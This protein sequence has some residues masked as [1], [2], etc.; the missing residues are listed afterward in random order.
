[1]LSTFK[2][3][4]VKQSI[5]RS[6][7]CIL[8]QI[9]MSVL[10]PATVWAQVS[11]TAASASGNFA[12]QAIGL[13]SA[14][15]T[16]S[17]SVSSG[18]TVG[19]VAVVTT[20]IVNLD[21]ANAAGSSCTAKLYSSA[22]ACAVN[23]TFTPTAAGLRMGAV[24]FYSKAKNA[25]TVLKSVP[26]YGIGIGPQ[27]AYGPGTLLV[28]DAAAFNGK[29][30]RTGL[31]N[32]RAVAADA[33]GNL[34]ILDDDNDP[35]GYRLV[36]VPAG[37]GTPT[38]SDP[39]VNGEALYLPSCL[40]VDG[41]GDLF[42]GDFYGRVVEVPTGGGTATAIYPAANGIA[43][44]Y[45]SGLAVDG[46]GDLFIA[47]FMN[48][49]VLEMPAAGGAA[50][51]ID[52][53]VNGVPLENP[54]GV[55]VDGAGD[56]FIADLANSR[57]IEVPAGGGAATAINPAVNGVRL[58]SPTGI[59]ADGAG[60]LFISDG[61]NH[62]VAVVAAGGGAA[63]SI[64]E[65]LYDEGLGEVY[66]VTVDG[67]G[68][69]FIVEGGLEGGHNIVE[70]L[71]RSKPPALA[72]PTLT[73]VG[74]TDITDGVQTVEIM[75]IGNEPLTLTA[76]GY[77][78]DFPE[79]GGDANACT[80]STNLSAGQDCDVSVEFSASNS[81]ALSEGVALSD[82]A[83]NASGAQQSIPAAATGEALAALIS[84]TPGNVLPGP[85]VTFTWTGSA[86]A[87]YYWLSVG[88]TGVGSNNL[89]M[90]GK[91]PIT[92]CT[93]GGLPTNGQTV[94]VRLTT[95]FGTVQLYTDYTYTAVTLAALTSPVPGAVLTGP[96]VTFSW[97]AGTSATGYS[98]WFGSTGV[99]SYNLKYT[100]ETTA[101]SSTVTG[102]PT[103]GQTIYVRLYT[104]FN[105]VTAHT[106]YTYTAAP[107]G[108]P[109]TMISPTSGST[110]GTSNVVF[111][112]TAGT[113][114][115][116]YNLWLGLSGPGSSSLYTSGWLTTTSTMVTKLP[117]KG[118]K[119]YAR[120]YSLVYG[121][122]QY[123]DYTYTEQ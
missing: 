27:I 85:T 108:T 28:I 43:L 79:V 84:P 68:D 41:A 121:V 38:A 98:M 35:V 61:M 100:S 19:S 66:G 53:T 103:N 8:V 40:A 42:I 50:I 65:T 95:Y 14:T 18:T 3:I 64:D 16:L 24:V 78:V 88:S 99:G 117:V 59:A 49:R 15:Q 109:A 104:Y 20:G 86:A 116:Q 120:L 83:L 21:F 70:E 72:F 55:A 69:L 111:N 123:N 33:A 90:T 92:S 44:N 45:P 26:L 30:S 96:S 5:L 73:A 71:Q 12:S 122:T 48:N 91:A 112:W 87:R 2:F 101:T 106:D 89:F 29:S 54:H 46:A 114:A 110:F 62:R 77:P 63:T 17:F 60:D 115:T 58:A 47:D 119:V 74:S 105:A 75:N 82:N 113:G 51:A 37:G 11:F 81:G 107:A 32:P 13:P 9:L 1:M 80:G 39:T 31:Q 57:V 97:K 6:H 36:T 94:Y 22:T 102:L 4:R 118:A 52:P 7:I 10:L 56:L 23:V 34:F 67:G 76:L 93:V 25:G